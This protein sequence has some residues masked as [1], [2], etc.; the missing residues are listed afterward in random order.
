[1]STWNWYH[2]QL[3][4]NTH[5]PPAFFTSHR[6][7]QWFHG[8]TDCSTDMR[9]NGD[10]TFL[11]FLVQ[12]KRGKVRRSITQFLYV[13][14]NSLSL[15]SS[16]CIRSVIGVPTQR[17]VYPEMG[18]PY[19]FVFQS[20]TTLLTFVF[21]RN[22]MSH[23]EYHDSHHNHCTMRILCDKSLNSFVISTCQNT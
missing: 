1:M 20:A 19:K 22:R 18:I 3:L 11:C 12:H 5:R 8:T 21:S 2:D 10:K 14:T 6:Q 16:A 15:E 17:R 7:Y 4:L 23:D 9:L 13:H